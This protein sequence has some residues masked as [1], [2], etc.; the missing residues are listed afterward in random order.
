MINKRIAATLSLAA[1]LSLG[2]EAKAGEL[3]TRDEEITMAYMEHLIFTELIPGMQNN[4]EDVENLAAI[5]KL[6]REVCRTRKPIIH[7][8]N[9]KQVLSNE[10]DGIIN[11]SEKIEK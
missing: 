1:V 8:E 10:L 4:G 5:T 3:V 7:C 6:A 2:T 11:N 9:V